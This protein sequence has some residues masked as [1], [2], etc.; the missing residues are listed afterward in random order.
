MCVL[1][2]NHIKGYIKY[3]ITQVE[4]NYTNWAKCC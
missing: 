4:P 2:I 3:P 1:N